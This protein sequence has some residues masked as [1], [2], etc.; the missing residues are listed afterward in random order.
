MCVCHRT[1]T[2]EGKFS[3][4]FFINLIEEENRL[5]KYK[6]ITESLIQN[7]LETRLDIPITSQPLQITTL[8]TCISLES[9]LVRR[10]NVL[11]KLIDN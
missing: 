9:A 6:I 10:Y 2:D 5:V 4:V 3:A 11:P 8:K 7:S 1:C